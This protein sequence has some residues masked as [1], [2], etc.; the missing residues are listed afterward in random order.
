MKFRKLL[1]QSCA[2]NLNKLPRNI[3]N[4]VDIEENIKK[5]RELIIKHGPKKAAEIMAKTGGLYKGDFTEEHK[6]DPMFSDEA[7]EKLAEAIPVIKKMNTHETE[8]IPANS[9]GEWIETL[10]PEPINEGQLN[11]I[12]EIYQR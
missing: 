7:T 8:I 12:A 5:Y 1:D 6:S 11:L 3:M 9:V 10:K 4:M 2:T